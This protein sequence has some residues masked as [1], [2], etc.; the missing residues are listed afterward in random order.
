[1][2]F[3]TPYS[4]K[5]VVPIIVAL[6]GA[7][8]PALAQTGEPSTDLAKRVER[9]IEQLGDDRFT[10][11]EQAQQELADIGAV[12]FDALA[13]AQT[14][15]DLEVAH[16]AR[17][18]VQSIRM[19]WVRDSDSAEVR[20]LLEDYDS[21][22]D[23]ERLNRIRQLVVKPQA[24][25]LA[26]LCRLVR[27][28]R[29]PLLSKQAALMIIGQKRPVPS[30]WSERSRIIRDEI[31]LSKRP[32]AE[33]LHVYADYADKPAGA[34]AAWA[35]IVAAEDEQT[36][37]LPTQEQRAIQAGLLRQQVIMLLDQRQQDEALL[38]LRRMLDLANTDDESLAEL[39]EW[40]VLQ[41]A[42][43]LIDE[44]VK[45]F[46]SQLSNNPYLI[47]LIAQAHDAR[48]E[49]KLAQAMAA[50]ALAQ[51]PGNAD[52]HY[53]VAY[54]LHEQGLTKWAEGE[55][56][57][58]IGD[59]AD[60]RFVVAAGSR[61]GELLNDGERF[62][63]A[64]D[65]LERVAGKM[66]ELPKE[67]RRRGLMERTA[68]HVKARALFFRAKQYAADKQTA[69][70]LEHL[71]KAIEL[72]PTEADVLI[73]LY[74]IEDQPETEREKTRVKIRKAAALFRQRIMAAP[75]DSTAM[76]QYA[77]LVANTE[78]D[79]DEATR[80]SQRSVEL[81]P[82]AAKGGYLDTLAHC[83]AAKKDYQAALKH[84]ARALELE[85]HT[86]EITRAYER[87]K[88]LHAQQVK[89]KNE[90]RSEEK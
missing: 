6:F 89:S 42:R 66:D 55:Y 33:W 81:A 75:E 61:L 88:K 90:G 84:Q 79:F 7:A 30:A 36:N 80:F 70:Q 21:Q 40:V 78:G 12:A 48:G 49:P 52:H 53:R 38:A 9:M 67:W 76:N 5:Y 43:E 39:I 54:R 51:Q 57:A 22:P 26:P 3:R 23:N 65:V 17:F 71:Q 24:E 85:P 73:A 8:Q 74:R 58:A 10:V 28:E 1:M 34:L 72:D 62:G 44:V 31:R 83:Y 87:F 27:F 47:Y 18:L 32:A 4:S 69:K 46:E 29:S 16:R 56:R 25:A 63:D 50:K 14:H 45:R 60:A 86:Q 19:E 77:W 11:R 20:K 35:K 68:D 13:A 82:D 59:G 2:K 37:R 41:E 64:A 15:D